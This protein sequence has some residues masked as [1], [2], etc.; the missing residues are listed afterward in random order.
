MKQVFTISHQTHGDVHDIITKC[1]RNNCS[2]LPCWIALTS[3]EATWGMVGQHPGITLRAGTV[4]ER[5]AWK[6]RRHGWETDKCDFC[7]PCFLKR[8]SLS[9]VFQHGLA[10]DRDLVWVCVRVW[11]CMK[12]K[13]HLL[14]RAQSGLCSRDTICT[15]V[16]PHTIN[17]PLPLK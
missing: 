11:V 9:V 2:N 10:G 14:I 16:K 17:Y 5:L 12:L 7:F 8:A 4:R 1:L 13:G 15:R 3:L 6:R